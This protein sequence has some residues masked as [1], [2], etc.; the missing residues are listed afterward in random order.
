MNWSGIPPGR[1]AAE[2]PMID[3]ARPS[4]TGET[5]RLRDETGRTIGIVRRPVQGRMSGPGAATVYAMPAVRLPAGWLARQR[6][7]GGAGAA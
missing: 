4:D 3:I 5:I 2:P 7:A 1:R 6:R